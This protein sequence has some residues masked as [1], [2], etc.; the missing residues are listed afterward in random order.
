MGQEVFNI[1]DKDS[2]GSLVYFRLRNLKEKSIWSEQ[3]GMSQDSAEVKS[4]WA[5]IV[6]ANLDSEA[7]RIFAGTFFETLKAMPD[8]EEVDRAMAKIDADGDG[9]V[10]TDS[11][12][13]PP[14]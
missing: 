7:K 5:K 3:I 4:A 14:L 2:D 10:S 11:D 6:E 9:K 13:C 8:P 12:A 1:L